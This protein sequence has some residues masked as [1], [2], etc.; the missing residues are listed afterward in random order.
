MCADIRL[1]HGQSAEFFKPKT[2]F[3]REIFHSLSP[4]VEFEFEFL[5]GFWPAYPDSDKSCDQ[6]VW[7]YGDP[8]HDEIRGLKRS[9]EYILDRIEENG[10]FT[11]IVGFSSGAAI[12]AIITSLLEKKIDSFPLMVPYSSIIFYTLPYNHRTDYIL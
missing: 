8:E 11:G 5:S 7:G 6:W 3:I 2:R 1:G 12:G 10:P 9:I 4:K